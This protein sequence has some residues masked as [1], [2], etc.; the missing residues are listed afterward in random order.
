M[1][2]T[3]IVKV[4]LL[5]LSFVYTAILVPYIK[6]KTTDA[7]QDRLRKIVVMGVRA[8]EMIYGSGYGQDK[9]QFVKEYLQERGYNLDT[10]E[11]QVLIESAV[12]EL[13]KSIE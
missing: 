3:V 12:L 13:K 5:L 2:I 1:D 6:S 9:Y 8:A 11:I 7:E 10:D 4:V